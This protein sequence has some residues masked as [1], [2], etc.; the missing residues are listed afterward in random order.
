MRDTEVWKKN[1]RTFFPIPVNSC[2][3]DGRQHSRFDTR[4]NILLFFFAGV[5]TTTTAAAT[6][7]LMTLVLSNFANR[8]CNARPTSSS[9]SS[10]SSVIV[11]TVPLPDDDRPR[12]RP[13]QLLPRHH[14]TSGVGRTITDVGSNDV[15][16]LR[17]S[18]S[19]TTRVHRQRSHRNI[20]VIMYTLLQH[21]DIYSVNV[22]SLHRVAQ[23]FARDT[24][25][26]F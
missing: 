12:S 2:L 24:E 7:I 21:S 6:S 17:S 1:R 4:A 11:E 16:I 10:S 13:P 9:S 20:Q 8:H 18:L 23:L 25:K 22:I 19:G 26:Q 5:M 3:L 14:A 15:E